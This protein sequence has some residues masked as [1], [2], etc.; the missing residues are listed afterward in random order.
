MDI[1][2]PRTR[3]WRCTGRIILTKEPNNNNNNDTN[4]DDNDNNNDNRRLAMYQ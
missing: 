1:V 3:G 2:V 4:N